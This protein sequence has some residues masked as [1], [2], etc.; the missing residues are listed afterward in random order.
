SRLAAR[1]GAIV[2]FAW[3]ER[4]VA[5]DRASPPGFVVHVEPAPPEIASTAPGIGVLALNA[6]VERIARRDPAQYQWTYKRYS[7]QPRTNPD[8]DANPYKR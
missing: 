5:P 3:C 2:V 1:S 8:V 7:R 4:L 6:G